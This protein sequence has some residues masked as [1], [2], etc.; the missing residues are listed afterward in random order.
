MKNIIKVAPFLVLAVCTWLTF[1][2][3]WIVPDI[4]HWQAKLFGD[5]KFYPALTIFIISLPPLLLLA[6]LKFFLLRK[7]TIN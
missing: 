1:T 6:L 7:K 4:N 2:N 3:S 5:N